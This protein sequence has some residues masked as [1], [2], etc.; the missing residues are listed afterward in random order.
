M[1]IDALKTLFPPISDYTKLSTD[2]VGLYSITSL[3][4]AKIISEIIK[5]YFLTNPKDLTITDATAG[6]GGN[7]LSFSEHF[8]SVVA[9]EKDSQR[10]H[11]LEKNINLYRKE[12]GSLYSNI[13]LMNKDYLEVMTRIDQ[14]IIFFDPPWG[15][16][17]Y[18]EHEYMELLL[19]PQNIVNICNM[20]EKRAKLIAIKVP[21][22]F[23][24]NSFI[25][26]INNKKI[27]IY[28]LNKMDLI[29]IKNT[30]I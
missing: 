5:S 27:N 18:K 4:N 13:V 17:G 25:K 29:I 6:L 3:R 10:F 22:N 9:V 30:N 7:V 1:N 19:G 8:K 14:D 2:D 12:N 16:R 11:M 21:I 15:G 20:L 23:N 28:K 26:L 24:F